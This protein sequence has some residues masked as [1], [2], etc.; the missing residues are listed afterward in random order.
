MATDL[1]SH[2]YQ[3]SVS[4]FRTFPA[5]STSSVTLS[6]PLASVLGSLTGLPTAG[7]ATVSLPIPSNPALAGAVLNAQSICLTLSNPSN[8]LSSNGLEGVI[9]N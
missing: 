6:S 1:S 2:L 3:T 4:I 7:S 5:L 8:L 9:G